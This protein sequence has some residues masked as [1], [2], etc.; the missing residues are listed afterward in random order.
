M[1][2]G[3]FAEFF[4]KSISGNRNRLALEVWEIFE[5]KR[6]G[7]RHFDFFPFLCSNTPFSRQLLH[8]KLLLQ[9]LLKLWDS[10]SF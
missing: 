8:L 10:P 7:S 9:H 6:R 2:G 1:M 4:A 5:K 3:F